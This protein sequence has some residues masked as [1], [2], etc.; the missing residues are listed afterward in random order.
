MYLFIKFLIRKKN[1]IAPEHMQK[2][3]SVILSKILTVILKF[4]YKKK[5]AK[6][7]KVRLRHKYSIT[8]LFFLF[9]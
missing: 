7:K 1:K 3:K 6:S 8:L 5:R 9:Y 2:L 4:L